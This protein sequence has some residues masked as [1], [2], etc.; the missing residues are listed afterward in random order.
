MSYDMPISELMAV[1]DKPTIFMGWLPC[2]NH[3]FAY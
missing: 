3:F 1:N 2:G